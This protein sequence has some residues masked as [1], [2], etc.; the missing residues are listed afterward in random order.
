MDY[1]K[2]V[3]VATR[4]LFDVINVL[5]K[6]ET[7][8][9]IGCRCKDAET[10]KGLSGILSRTLQ[11]L[12]VEVKAREDNVVVIVPLIPPSSP[13]PSSPQHHLSQTPLPPSPP[14]LS[15]EQPPSSS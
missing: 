4:M 2:L 11:D 14:S 15:E 3:K 1:L 5:E 9:E 8:Y 13:E 6:K 12:A 10:A 7:E